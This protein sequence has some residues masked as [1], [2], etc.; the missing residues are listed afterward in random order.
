[1]DFLME[2]LMV[3]EDLVTNNVYPMDWSEMIMLQNRL[4]SILC[5]RD[6]A[7]RTLF[8]TVYD[9]QSIVYDRQSIVYDRQSM[10][11]ERQSIVYDRQSM[12]YDR[13]SI[14][15]DRQSMVYERQSIVY[16]RQSI[17]YH[18]Q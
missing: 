4:N 10:V 12:V 7:R 1:M 3:F 13:Q 15:Y 14:V 2:I 11:Y 6:G 9:R 8:V 17:A 18:I 16:D 5:D